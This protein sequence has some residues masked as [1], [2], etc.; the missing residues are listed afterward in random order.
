M[1]FQLFPVAGLAICLDIFLA[2]IEHNVQRAELDD[3]DVKR[4]GPR[5]LDGDV[6][7]MPQHIGRTHGAVKI[8]KNV[9]IGTLEFDEARRDPER[10]QP[11]RHGD[12]DFALDL[13]ADQAA[14]GAHEIERCGLHPL[15]RG[16]DLRSFLREAGAVN[17]TRE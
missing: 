15:D 8:D 12:A 2:G 17:V 9:R 7:L 16:Y 5:Q 6:G 11:F 4:R 13:R 3:L 14:A 10:T 1:L